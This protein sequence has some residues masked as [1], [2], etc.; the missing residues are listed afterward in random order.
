[1]LPYLTLARLQ[2]HVGRINNEGNRCAILLETE[3]DICFQW[4]GVAN[5]NLFHI[6][7]I[8]AFLVPVSSLSCHAIHEDYLQINGFKS[9]TPAVME[10]NVNSSSRISAVE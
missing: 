6:L 4:R 10:F 9:K 1:M 2:L 3:V 8:L 5:H 7:W